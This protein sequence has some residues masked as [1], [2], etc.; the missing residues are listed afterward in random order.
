L[1]SHFTILRSLANISQPQRGPGVGNPALFPFHDYCVAFDRPQYVYII[2]KNPS[3]PNAV[4]VQKAYRDIVSGVCIQGNEGTRRVESLILLQNDKPGFLMTL[5]MIYDG[6]IPTSADFKLQY[7][8]TAGSDAVA[9]LNTD[10][11]F[12]VVISHADGRLERRRVSS[13]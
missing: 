12:Y 7:Q 13:T 2:G 5:S 3:K 1:A 10:S 6:A 8:F 9:V 4:L 11:K